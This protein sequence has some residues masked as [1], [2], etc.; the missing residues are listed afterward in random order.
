MFSAGLIALLAATQAFAVPVT[1]RATSAAPVVQ[2]S[3]GTVT[4]SSSFG[5]DTFNGIPFALPPTGDLRLRPPQPITKPYGSF[6]ATGNPKAC[7]QFLSGPD[8]TDLPISVVGL[9]LQTPLLQTI[10]NYG[11]DCLN[12]NVQRPSGTT[13][14]SNLPV[15]VYIF[16]GGFE[17]GWSSMYNGNN[18]IA[19]SVMLGKPIMFVA[20]NYRVGGFGFL[21]GS[22]LAAEGS[23][24]L[25]LRDQRL[26]LQWV[27]DN[28]AAFGGDPTKV[29][30]WGESAGAISVFDHTVIN[31]GDNTYKGKP[32][33]RAAIMD[34]GSV[35]PADPVTAPQA[36][37]IY[38]DVLNTAGCASAADR[39]ACLRSKDFD[40]F[41]KA[42]SS[43]PGIFSY[44]S[45]DLSYLPR[46]DPGSNFFSV[47][48]EISI[49]NKQFTKVP[50]II[51]DQ[52]DEGTLFSLSTY[53][54]TSNAKLIDYL[55]TFFTS[56]PNARYDVTNLVSNYP[57][58]LGISGSPFGTGLLYNLYPQ[59]KRLAAIFG[60]VVF[61]LAR[62]VY[63]TNIATQVPCWSYL[64]SYLKGTPVLGTFHG[65]DIL[66]AFG[67]APP[68]VATDS[69]QNYYVAFIN[70]LDPNGLGTPGLTIKWPQWTASSPMLLNFLAAFN[71]LIPDTFRAGAGNYLLINPYAFRV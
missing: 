19:K 48:P 13:A 70:T 33:F 49:F 53:N 67:T 55:S 25:G 43:A 11:E 44:R 4:G 41:L 10:I 17:L 34:S 20:M 2:L 42:T 51:G 61:T 24:N 37:Q 63:L 26:A 12:L 28:I 9:L 1:E 8:L 45:L 21:A 31:G 60:D 36:Q 27:Q 64:A 14:S 15:V 6:S 58:D 7:P 62:R 39:L 23:T 29:T 69:I 38:Q 22:D 71:S 68:N 50:V 66:Y 16:G 30:I 46:P 18:L 54:V 40:T 3:L 47:S 5:I 52:E 35:I 32:M 59:Y 56:N 57:D 65:S